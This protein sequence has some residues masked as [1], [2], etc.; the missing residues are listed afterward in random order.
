MVL[1]C[2]FLLPWMDDSSCFDSSQ[3]D[4]DFSLD[5]GPLK[6]NYFTNY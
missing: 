5:R 6:I 1:P 3:E 4:L 2:V